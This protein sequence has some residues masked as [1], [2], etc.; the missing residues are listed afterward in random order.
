[1][2][3]PT[4]SRPPRWAQAPVVEVR[5]VRPA[6][7]ERTIRVLGTALGL[8]IFLPL[9]FLALGLAIAAVESGD[10]NI[11]SDFIL[12]VENAV[13]FLVMLSDDV[14][15]AEGVNKAQ[16]LIGLVT[17]ALGGGE[18]YTSADDTEPLAQLQKDLL[19]GVPQAQVEPEQ[20][21]FG[22]YL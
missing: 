1:M 10:P 7:D 14:Q 16:W 19:A 12:G 21:H 5:E 8:A 3:A 22:L 17:K 4:A 9:H 20:D 18:P 11:T 15:D 13:N 2:S 6:R